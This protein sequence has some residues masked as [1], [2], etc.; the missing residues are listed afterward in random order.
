MAGPSIYFPLSIPCLPVCFITPHLLSSHR[1]SLQGHR[2]LTLHD[3]HRLG[4]VDR[5][6]DED[7]QSSVP[8]QSTVLRPLLRSSLVARLF[9]PLSRS[10][11]EENVQLCPGSACKHE[12]PLLPQT[13]GDEG[14]SDQAH[15]TLQKKWVDFN[16]NTIWNPVAHLWNKKKDGKYGATQQGLTGYQAV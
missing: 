11:R 15:F 14:P 6:A 2:E 1:L 16:N 3:S 8:W 9:W 7:G 5:Q 13:Y 10:S 4:A 12:L